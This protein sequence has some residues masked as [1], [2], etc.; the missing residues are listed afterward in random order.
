[1]E[2]FWRQDRSWQSVTNMDCRGWGTIKIREEALIRGAKKTFTNF[3][4]EQRQSPMPKKGKQKS[5][6]IIQYHVIPFSQTWENSVYKQTIS[7]GQ[8]RLKHNQEL[9]VSLWENILSL[10]YLF[11]YIDYLHMYINTHLFIQR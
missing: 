8:K 4:I 7:K 2:H 5:S 6:F 11:M 1:M 3:K 10:K 9:H